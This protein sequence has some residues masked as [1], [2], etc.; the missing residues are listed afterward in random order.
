MKMFAPGVAVLTFATNN[1]FVPTAAAA[2]ANTATIVGRTF[3]DPNN[4]LG[5][6][7]V[8]LAGE[9]Q[10]LR[11]AT[12]KAPLSEAPARDAAA[13]ATPAVE[14]Q[15]GLI[16]VR[17]ASAD[18]NRTA[19]GTSSPDQGDS[20]TTG[21]RQATNNYQ[22]LG[23]EEGATF[24]QVK[25]AYRDL[26]KQYHPDGNRNQTEQ[27]K[28]GFQEIT[29]AYNVLKNDRMGLSR[30]DVQGT[31]SQGP[32]SDTPRQL[33]GT[34][35]AP[36]PRGQTEDSRDAEDSSRRDSVAASREALEN[37][38][39][40]LEADYNYP[41]YQKDG[42]NAD[43]DE[44]KDKDTPSFDSRP[45]EKTEDP[46]SSVSPARSTSENKKESPAEKERKARQRAASVA[47][48]GVSAHEILAETGIDA[49]EAEMQ[50]AK[51]NIVRFKRAATP[52][53]TGPKSRK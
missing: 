47:G 40:S 20:N 19:E 26:A 23:L 52:T 12:A 9:L 16:L 6:S 46:R 50:A 22:R 11:E 31:P 35:V 48:D 34:T 53:P 28:R 43:S 7:D 8:N 13:R 1:L 2:A 25:E 51:N 14:Q 4:D 39:K 37:D 49:T 27:E 17:K 38:R 29:A 45:K 15:E 32:T 42:D 44:D 18:L 10:N 41:S 3:L 5:L 21:E 30:D 33:S 24:D 36:I